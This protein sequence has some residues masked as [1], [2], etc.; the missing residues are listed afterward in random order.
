MRRAWNDDRIS[1]CDHIHQYHYLDSETPQR[2][3]CA[4][5]LCPRGTDE[6]PPFLVITRHGDKTGVSYE[7]HRERRD[8]SWSW[9]MDSVVEFRLRGSDG[10]P[11]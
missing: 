11:L 6:R 10:V 7:Y 2:L 9:E 4:D 5:P 3:P 1:E 8:N